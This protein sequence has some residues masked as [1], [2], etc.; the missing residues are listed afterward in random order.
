M[1]RPRKVSDKQL[2]KGVDEY[3]ENAEIPIV[4]EYANLMGISKNRLYER[5]KDNEEL[6][7]AIK[8]ITDR[9]EIVLEKGALTGKYDRSMAIFSLKQ[10]G[11]S[12][13][14]EIETDI[15]AEGIIKIPEIKGREDT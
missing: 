13:K 6:S 9:K 1:G 14:Q 4:T 12:D 2:I 15:K 8:R 7:T 3:L 11:W 5:M 10:L